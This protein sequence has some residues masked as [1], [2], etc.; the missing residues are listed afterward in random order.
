MQVRGFKHEAPM[1]DETHRVHCSGKSAT[2]FPQRRSNYSIVWIMS[3]GKNRICSHKNVR[4]LVIIICSLL[5][6]VGVDIVR[7]NITVDSWY[8]EPCAISNQNHFLL[9][10]HHTFTVILPPL[11][12]T[13]NNSN[14]PVTRSSF[15]LPS[16]NFNIILPL[17]TQTTF[18]AP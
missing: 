12:R 13:V 8:L 3:Q 18:W 11:T 5:V 16:D 9:D 15:C 10:F 14:L 7:L 6:H 1:T 2:F 4:N 17:I